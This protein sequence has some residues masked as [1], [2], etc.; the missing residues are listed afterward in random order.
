MLWESFHSEFPDQGPIQGHSEFPDQGPNQNLKGP[1]RVSRSGAYSEFFPDKGLFRV[2][3][4]GAHS[5]PQGPFRFSRSRPIQSFQT[6]GH[7]KSPDPI[8]GFIQFQDQKPILGFP[9]QGSIQS[10]RSG[11]HSGFQSRAQT[12]FPNEGPRVSRPIK[13]SRSG[14]IQNF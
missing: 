14:P 8:Q 12:E 3:R 7:S 4:S 13:S 11:A 9:D 1:F 10:S 6:R 2:S 5:E